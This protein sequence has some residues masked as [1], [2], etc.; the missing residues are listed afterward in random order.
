VRQGEKNG[1]KR[2]P[3]LLPD[4][5]QPSPDGSP[6]MTDVY[7]SFSTQ[8]RHL[9]LKPLQAPRP[10]PSSNTRFPFLSS[11]PSPSL[12]FSPHTSPHHVQGCKPRRSHQSRRDSKRG[13]QRRQDQVSCRRKRT[14]ER[15]ATTSRSSSLCF[16]LAFADRSS[17]YTLSRR[18]DIFNVLSEERI[19]LTDEQVRELGFLVGFGPPEAL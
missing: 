15:A 18:E 3:P 13:R 17:G 1:E 5:L 7:K 2:R 6:D 4:T 14:D 12:L 10:S 9:L 16:V 11:H 19:M 8:P